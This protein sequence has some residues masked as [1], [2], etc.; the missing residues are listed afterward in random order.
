MSG[1]GQGSTGGFGQGAGSL[2]GFGAQGFGFGQGQ[3]FGST[4]SSGGF[5]QGQ[6]FGVGSSP[7]FG[8]FGQGQ[9]GNAYAPNFGGAGLYSPSTGMGGAGYIQGTAAPGVLENYY[10]PDMKTSAGLNKP[11]YGTFNNFSAKDL[12][13]FV[14]NPTTNNPQAIQSG[15]QQY[16]VSAHDLATSGALTPQQ[17]TEMFRPSSGVQQGLNQNQY[18]QP[19]YQAQ[20]QNYASPAYASMGGANNMGMY[21]Q[22][23]RSPMSYLSGGFN[24]YA[25]SY[26]QPSYGNQG[27]GIDSLLGQ[28]GGYLDQYMSKYQQP[29]TA[30]QTTTAA[31]TNTT[32]AAPTKTDTT[33]SAPTN[34]TTA[35]PTKTDTTT[36]APTNTTTAAPTYG[37]ANFTA[38]QVTDFINQNKG[39]PQAIFDAAKQYGISD[40]Q[41]A[42]AG[43][44]AANPND[45]SAANIAAYRAAYGA[46]KGGLMSLMGR[47]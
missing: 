29:T 25:N 9:M 17:Y 4:P 36:S 7:S 35:V 1:G 27:Y 47:Q 30:A 5:N 3:G 10:T 40:A 6:S 26:V 22:M 16:G 18:Y 39:N 14:N 23:A 19:I 38:Q 20:Y 13:N 21:N 15:M 44:S 12:Q 31:P 8:G 2:G 37:N 11:Y 46:K 42:E 24:P 34:T 32:T 41:I 45:F 43:K 33:T 28:L